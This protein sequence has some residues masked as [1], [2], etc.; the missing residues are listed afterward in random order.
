MEYDMMVSPV[1]DRGG[2]SDGFLVDL[3]TF[4]SMS[5]SHRVT[6]GLISESE[7]QGGGSFSP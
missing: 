7:I 4:V 1:H 3:G 6:L 2:P 5:G